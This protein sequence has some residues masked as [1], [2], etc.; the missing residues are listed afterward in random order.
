MPTPTSLIDY[1]GNLVRAGKRI[2]EGV[3]NKKASRIE[4]PTCDPSPDKL[5]YERQGCC[6]SYSV[7]SEIRP[8]NFRMKAVLRR[9]NFNDKF[10][11]E[12]VR[13]DLPLSA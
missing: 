11:I 10:T 6:E 3:P 2:F 7:T 13:E 9:N 1:L 12:Y 4:R 8:C 5:N